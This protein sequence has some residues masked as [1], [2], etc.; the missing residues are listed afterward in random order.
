MPGPGPSLHFDHAGARPARKLGRSRVVDLGHGQRQMQGQTLEAEP[1]RRQGGLER[2]AGHHG[3][4]VGLQQAEPAHAGDPLD[5]DAGPGWQLPDRLHVADGADDPPRERPVVHFGPAGR[6]DRITGV[7][8]HQHEDVA[9]EAGR[10]LGHLE[11]GA[12]RQPVHAQTGGLVGQGGQPEAVA[13]ALR[14]RHEIPEPG[15]LIPT[16]DGQAQGVADRGGVLPPGGAVDLQRERHVRSLTS[17]AAGVACGW[18]PRRQLSAASGRPRRPCS[19]TPAAPGPTH[20]R[21]PGRSRRSR[22]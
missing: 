10:D 17:R 20:P 6:G 12:H 13:V 5:G 14:H 7:P 11:D 18:R 22:P 21:T 15:G 9:G 1:P 4:Q 19:T 8:G 16:A 3:Q 2:L